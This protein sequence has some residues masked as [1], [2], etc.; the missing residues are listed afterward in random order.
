ME[1]AVEQRYDER[2]EKG[3]GGEGTKRKSERVK[4]ARTSNADN[5]I[6]QLKASEG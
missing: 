5:V 6:W 2:V 3:G 1:K 4:S